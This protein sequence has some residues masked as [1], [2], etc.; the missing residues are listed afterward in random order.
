MPGLPQCLPQAAG[1]L[2]M[3][4]F[5]RL[6]RD[7]WRNAT[8]CFKL[9]LISLLSAATPCHG[10]ACGIRRLTSP[11]GRV[12]EIERGRG[13]VGDSFVVVCQTKRS[14]NSPKNAYVAVRGGCGSEMGTASPRAYPFVAP[15]PHSLL[16]GALHPVCRYVVL[17]AL[18]QVF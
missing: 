15:L 3:K 14:C 10:V 6:P 16:L 12:C 13:K 2:N 4:H 11:K 1:Q 17:Q 5:F 8:V 7:A 9:N 18:L